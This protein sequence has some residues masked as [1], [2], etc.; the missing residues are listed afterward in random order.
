MLC[1]ADN[2]CAKGVTH[3]LFSRAVLSVLIKANELEKSVYG[4]ESILLHQ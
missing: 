2:I 1:D 3:Y 4:L